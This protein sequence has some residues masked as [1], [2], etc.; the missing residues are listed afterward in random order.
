MRAIGTP[1]TLKREYAR[2]TLR[3]KPVHKSD[4]VEALR[5]Q[6]IAYQ[7]TGELLL[8]TL[9]AFDIMMHDI[10]IKI[11]KDFDASPLHKAS[12]VGGYTLSACAVGFLLSMITFLLGKAYIV[13]NGGAWLSVYKMLRVIGVV[14]LSVLSCSTAVA[15]GTDGCA[16]GQS[17]YG[18]TF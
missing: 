9:G 18:R 6:Q 4:M 12:I 17:V 8:I 3:I 16:N 13:V 10:D 1:T 15:P 2:D 7:D 5:Q 11:S 14:A